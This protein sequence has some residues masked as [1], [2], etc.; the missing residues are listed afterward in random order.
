METE[1]CAQ[2]CE[3]PQQDKKDK[4]DESQQDCYLNCPLCYV[5]TLASITRLSKN[6]GII[7]REY[8][9]FA[10]NYIFIFCSSTW[11]PPDMC[12]Y[13]SYQRI[14]ESILLSFKQLIWKR[15]FY[16][17]QHSCCWADRSYLQTT[18]IRI[19]TRARSPRVRN[20][21]VASLVRS[22]VRRPAVIK[23]GAAKA[24]FWYIDLK[25]SPW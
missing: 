7:E 25:K 14:R 3:K 18:E 19:R 22:L 13:I 23:A 2:S 4:T 15:H 11:K 6:T 20:R 24:K 21:P 12:W 1:C 8:S 10:F 17:P 5:T 16:W 9:L